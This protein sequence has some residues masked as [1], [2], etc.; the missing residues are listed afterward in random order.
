MEF[1][2]ESDIDPNTKTIEVTGG[3]GVIAEG[4]YRGLAFKK[5]GKGKEFI[6]YD[7][8]FLKRVEKELANKKPLNG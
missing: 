3:Y 1:P 7:F 6:G 8:D 4:E 2:K 5:D